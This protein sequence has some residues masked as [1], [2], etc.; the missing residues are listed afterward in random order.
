MGAF[1]RLAFGPD[2]AAMPFNDALYAGQPDAGALELVSV[3]QPLEHTE[4]GVHILPVKARAIVAY[5]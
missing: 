4:Q 5:K 3:V 1:A 2:S